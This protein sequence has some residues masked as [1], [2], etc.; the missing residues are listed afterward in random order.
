[1]PNKSNK[2]HYFQGDLPADLKLEGTLAIDTETTG[3]SLVRDRLCLLQ[4]S[5]GDGNAY[6]VHFPNREYDKALNLKK[7]LNN[8]EIQKVFHF[9]RFDLAIIKK[10]LGVAVRN[11]FCTKIASKLARTNTESHSFKSVMRDILDIEISKEETCSDW[12]ASKL[13]DKQLSYAAN[14]VFELCELKEKLAEL[15]KREGRA[16]IAQKCFDFLPT[17]IDLDLQ[18]FQFDIFAH[19]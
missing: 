18:D 15:L 10:C 16:D 8:P 9:A 19:H 6:L 7:I 1:M 12:G 4:I 17:L 11:I 2:I 13:T 5:N 3:L 14:D